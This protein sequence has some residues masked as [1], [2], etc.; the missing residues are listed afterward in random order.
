[1]ATDSIKIIE[2]I[3]DDQKLLRIE[4]QDDDYY[5]HCGYD[6]ITFVSKEIELKTFCSEDE[7]SEGMII[8]ALCLKY[9]SSL[10]VIGCPKSNTS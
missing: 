1:M 3:D 5:S 9:G 2:D 6:Q 4:G 7:L 8:D 10:E